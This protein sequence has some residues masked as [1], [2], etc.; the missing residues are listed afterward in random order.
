MDIRPDTLIADVARQHPSTVKVFQRLGID[1]CCGGRR[2]L[3]EACRE[4]GLDY[5]VVATELEVARQR[6]AAGDD[7]DQRPLAELTRHIVQ[8]Y[9]EAVRRDGPLLG[10]LAAKVA[11]RHGDRHPELREVETLFRQVQQEMRTHMAK[12]ERVLFPL[13]ERLET[14]G[15]ALSD[16]LGSLDGPIAAMEDDHDEVA[17]LLARIRA[18]TSGFL[19]PPDSCNSFRGLY[20]GLADLEADTH[21]HIHLENNVLFPRAQEMAERAAS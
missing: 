6:P 7:W 19:P 12:E 14:S 4:H 11:S 13:I 8:R 17:R 9:H 3:E 18:L 2:P 21:H 1:F 10:E 15:A 16:F 20:Q 5:G